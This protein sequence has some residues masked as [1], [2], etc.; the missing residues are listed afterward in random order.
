MPE[1]DIPPPPSGWE[2]FRPGESWEEYYKAKTGGTPP[3]EPAPGSTPPPPDARPPDTRRGSSTDSSSDSSSRRGSYDGWAS[4][5]EPES[6]YSDDEV[7]DQDEEKTRKP[8]RDE[9]GDWT[10]DGRKIASSSSSGGT[11]VFRFEDGG[12]EEFYRDPESGD[13]QYDGPTRLIWEADGTRPTTTRVREYNT[14]ENNA[15]EWRIINDDGSLGGRIEDWGA[16]GDN[17][18]AYTDGEYRQAYGSRTEM[19]FTNSDG[20][21][22]TVAEFL[23]YF[24]IG[25]REGLEEDLAT[26][27]QELRNAPDTETYDDLEDKLRDRVTEAINA[28]HLEYTGEERTG[29]PELDAAAWQARTDEINAQHLEY[30][31]EERTGNPELD[32]AAWQARTDEITAQHLEY[33]GEE[34]T[35]NPELDAAAW[36]ARTDEITAQHLEYTGEEHTGNPE[37]D[38]A[39][40]QARTDEITAQHLEYTGEEHT[41]NPELDA[42]AWQARTDEITAQHLEYTGEEHT[43]N[44]ELDAAAWQAR[45]DEINA[46]NAE[47]RQSNHRNLLEIAQRHGYGTVREADAA[48]GGVDEVWALGFAD[49]VSSGGMAVEAVPEEF[50]ESVVAGLVNALEPNQKGEVERLVMDGGATPAEALAAVYAQ[51][52]TGYEAELATYHADIR[53]QINALEPNQ[54]GEIE[55]LVMDGGATPAEALAAVYAQGQT[56]YEANLAT[57]HADIR[58][59][60]NALEPNQKG[61][62]ERLVATPAEA[63]AAVYAQGQTAYEANLATYHADIRR[64]I[65]ALEPNQKGEI[66]RLVMDGGATPAEALAAVYAQDIRRQINALEPNQ[67]GEIERLVMD[68]GATPAEALAAVYAQDIRRQINALE[69]NQKGE[70]ERLMDGGATPAEALAA[71]YAQDIRRQIN[72]LEPNQKGEIERL[73]MDGGATPAEALAA[74]YAQGQTAYE[75]DIRRQINALE[76]N[77]KGEIERLVMDGGATPAEAL[78]AVYA[79]GQTG[80]EAELPHVAAFHRGE[81]GITTT[82]YG[83]GQTW[84]ELVS[85]QNLQ[86]ARDIAEARKVATTP[87]EAA[88]T[89]AAQAAA[90]RKMETIT[91]DNFDEV[92]AA[93][94]DQAYLVDEYGSVKPVSLRELRVIGGG[95]YTVGELLTRVQ[96]EDPESPRPDIP[97]EKLAQ[98]FREGKLTFRGE[99]PPKTVVVRAPSMSYTLGRDADF[100][101]TWESPEQLKA[102]LAG[103]DIERFKTELAQAKENGYIVFLDTRGSLDAAK[104]FLPGMGIVDAGGVNQRMRAD[105]LSTAD[106]RTAMAWAAGW[107]ALDLV[108]AFFWPTTM[109]PAGRRVGAAGLSTALKQP[110]A[111]SMIQPNPTRFHGASFVS[112]KPFLQRSME[113]QSYL[114]DVNRHVA[115]TNPEHWRAIQAATGGRGYSLQTMPALQHAL[116]TENFDV[117]AML[118][119]R[120]E[121]VEGLSRGKVTTVPTISPDVRLQGRPSAFQSA[122]AGPEGT[123]SHGTYDV[124]PLLG[125][126]ALDPVERYIRT[127]QPGQ[128]GLFGAPDVMVG[129]VLDKPF[130]KAIQRT[131]GDQRQLRPGY[132]MF[133]GGDD[134]IVT[135][136]LSPQNVQRA[137]DITVRDLENLGPSGPVVQ[138]GVRD[139][140]Q[141]VT[142]KGAMWV[143]P[144]GAS[145]GASPKRLRATVVATKDDGSVLLVRGKDDNLWMLPG[146]DVK[147]GEQVVD[148]AAR[149]LWEETGLTALEA[150]RRFGLD[151]PNTWHEVSLARVGDDVV[152]AQRGEI[153]DWMWWNG[154]T[155]VPMNRSTR[156]ILGWLLGKEPPKTGLRMVVRGRETYDWWPRRT[157]LGEIEGVLAVGSGI[158]IDPKLTQRIFGAPGSG[159]RLLATGRSANLPQ[160]PALYF[161]EGATPPTRGQIGRANLEQ[162]WRL[163]TGAE[164]SVDYVGPSGK[165]L[166]PRSTGAAV[167]EL[168]GRAVDDLDGGRAVDELDG[169]AVDE[170]NGRA[171]DELDGRAVDELDGRAVDELDGRAVDEL[172]GRAVDELDGRAVDDLDG[173]RAVDELDRVRAAGL[174]APNAADVRGLDELTRPGVSELRT[175]PGV[176]ELRTGPGV[177]ELRTGPGVSD[178]RT[179]PG[180]SGLGVSELRTGPGVSGLGVSELQTGPGVSGPSVSEL[181][182]GPGVSGPSVSELRTGPGVSGLG[183][184]E[185]R[186]GPGVSGLGVSELQTGPGVSGLGVSELRT[187]PGVSGPSVSELR[188]GP[189]VSGLGVSELRTGPGVSG[190]GVSGPS[191]SELRKGPGVS[192]LGVSEL[193]T[194]PS[195]SGLGV[196]GLGVSELRTGPGVSGPS[197]SELRTGPGVSERTPPP[198]PELR[199]PPPPPELRTP[200]PPPELRTPPPPPPEL[201][202]PPPRRLPRFSRLRRDGQPSQ[203]FGPI[204]CEVYPEAVGQVVLTDVVTDLNT[205]LTT[206]AILDTVTQPRV[207]DRQPD[208]ARPKEITGRNMDIVV[209]ADGSANVAQVEDRKAHFIELAGQH[210]LEDLDDIEVTALREPGGRRMVDTAAGSIKEAAAAAREASQTAKPAWSRQRNRPPNLR[211]RSEAKPRRT[212]TSPFYRLGHR[213][214]GVR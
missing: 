45:T 98:L 213:K 102:E 153:G 162:L 50:R 204:E 160:A 40:W 100:R 210:D 77:Q 179:G 119:A 159:Q 174:L 168:D 202:T 149:E 166:S 21:A 12:V 71:V 80:Y 209:R 134:V 22:I 61:E 165:V 104:G 146:G 31:G 194:G 37:L 109:V 74:V 123:F 114:Q 6:S 95:D 113:L 30:T 185:L 190:P 163:A 91:G 158:D 196:S 152:Q 205:G 33:T 15:S 128:L 94:P 66:E 115:A 135:P 214:H 140:A 155:A 116:V 164:A 2:H 171:V 56:A 17:V 58:R 167:D 87:E 172:D 36:Q 49:A 132:V 176:S 34:H 79:Q 93:V 131:V 44:P 85:V 55:R 23:D 86:V 156:T 53:R 3:P 18:L 92:L 201:R 38:A 41:G 63:L 117:A 111:A 137:N 129:E 29:N 24:P 4:E 43:G 143:Q 136:K 13:V 177:S 154:E 60:I 32:A 8:V 46:E 76:P 83:E 39:A 14:G 112:T 122:Y 125:E 195:V 28:L 207:V 68:G 70:I 150:D 206:A 169:R 138:E 72:A 139:A 107:A 200:P 78:A 126:G 11:V 157:S 198:P 130:S 121:L 84:A 75:A 197:V 101:R 192:G 9:D 211:A 186:T 54:K 26:V 89:A 105:G 142:V 62:I 184:S 1:N 203:R 127:R 81:S 42:A 57:Y 151:A 52:Q 25:I 110:W 181:R 187:G 106:E 161:R 20:D 16:L 191:V 19:E 7:I 188:T 144:R 145:S 170:L 103:I 82:S 108:D 147:A 73:V 193:R 51:G 199:T 120:G 133:E 141:V 59:Q 183:V 99:A 212:S 67:K 65:N 175:G 47:I 5:S 10:I 69:P 208:P 148:A 88:K 96:W 189:G 97:A 124:S 27:G 48:L 64:Q 180:V 173:G 178:L 35:G 118:R 182:T 90:D